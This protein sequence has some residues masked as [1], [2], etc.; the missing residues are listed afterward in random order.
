M[1]GPADADFDDLDPPDLRS[2]HV[3]VV[4]NEKGGTGKSTLSI[5]LSVALMKAGFRVEIGRAHV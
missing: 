5:H 1:S 2:A 3:I 4:G